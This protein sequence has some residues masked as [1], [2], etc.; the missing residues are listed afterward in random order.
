MDLPAEQQQ[1]LDRA[2]F[3]HRS[4]NLG[5]AE[6]LYQELLAG[7]PGQADALHYLGVIRLQTSHFDEAVR[8]I[9]RA[10]DAR[11]DYGDAMTNLGIGLNALGRF[12]EAVETFE[13]ALG[14]GT[15]TAAVLANL[16][17]ALAC[18]GRNEDAITRFEE[19]LEL[20][21]E[22][23][24]VRGNLANLLRQAGRFEEAV[25]HYEKALLQDPENVEGR[26]QLGV[27]FQDH[28]EKDRALAAFRE[29]VEK[30][31]DHAKAWHGIAAVSRNAF[32]DDEVSALLALAAR[33]ETSKDDRIRL[34]F[35]L[36]RHFEN[37]GRHE[38]AAAQFPD[39]N[40]LRRAGLDYDVNNDLRAMQN[41]KRCFDAAF[42]DAWSGAGLHDEKPIFIVGMPRSGTTLVEQI[43]ASHPEVFGAGEQMLMV[44][45][46][47]AA[48]PI[49][50]GLDYTD[51]LAS[52][53]DEKFRTVAR[54][55]L[56]GLPG[57]RAERITDKLTHNFLNVGMIR[58]L[59][60]NATVIHCR[61]DPRDTC[62][63]IYKHLFG[64]ESHIY[65]YDLQELAR[66][67]NGYT[68]L[69]DHWER[70]L[71]GFM[72]TVQYE[73]IVDNQEQSTRDLLDACGLDW[74]PACLEFHKHERLV[75]TISASQVRQPVY[76]GSIGAWKPY[77]NMLQPLLQLLDT[78]TR[79]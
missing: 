37:T 6:K 50:N 38:E 13:R 76:R 59:F 8:L 62:F 41:L 79:D 65:A 35:A 69:M 3:I 71:P 55:Y 60:P 9:Q 48:F 73:A 15:A 10:L 18:I 57:E 56:A 5:E 22:L 44:N 67:Y 14:A 34:G 23:L 20:Q 74:D 1:L 46:I 29:V 39:A 4:G 17:G 66:Y 47:I 2:L 36:G 45:A 75:A 78:Q 63:S 49:L 19:A 70:V 68:E 43:L 58:I 30:D 72:H 51:A 21:P 12:A 27:L 24:P 42:F 26:Y 28:G 53:S 16:G 11:P 64:S 54:Q 25:R 77:E 31:E 33:P 52:A 40:A 61:R 32:S 7:D